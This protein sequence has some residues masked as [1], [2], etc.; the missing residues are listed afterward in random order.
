MANTGNGWNLR[1]EFGM[2]GLQCRET[3][4]VSDCLD[5][6]AS[7]GSWQPAEQKLHPQTGGMRHILPHLFS[8]PTTWGKEFVTLVFFVKNARTEEGCGIHR[9]MQQMCMYETCRLRARGILLAPATQPTSPGV[10][11]K[12]T[13]PVL[14]F[15]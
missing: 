14:A 5:C 7:R 9:D 15:T 11:L 2:L 1:M 3:L 6:V 8:L 12:L 10:T 13:F 4:D